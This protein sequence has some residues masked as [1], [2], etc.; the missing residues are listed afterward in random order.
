VF[1]LLLQSLKGNVAS[2]FTCVV[3]LRG[4]AVLEEVWSVPCLYRHTFY[5][6]V[7][8]EA[9]TDNNPLPGFK[10]RR[11]AGLALFGKSSSEPP[12]KKVMSQ[13]IPSHQSL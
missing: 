8:A 3:A 11:G 12:T 9:N 7:E 4:P 5:L 1:D 2:S 6:Q 13:S 10:P